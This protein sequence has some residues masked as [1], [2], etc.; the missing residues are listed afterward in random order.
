MPQCQVSLEPFAIPGYLGT[1]SMEEMERRKSGRTHI[2]LFTGIGGFDLGLH[3]AGFESRVMIEINKSCCKTLRANW[4]WEE[5]QKRQ[6]GKIVDNKFVPTGPMWKTKEEMKKSITWYQDREPVIIERDIRTVST[7]EILEAAELSVGECS[8]I[9]G[10]PPCQGFSTAN[11]GRCTDDP[12]NFAFKA[13]VRIVGEA[14]P[15]TFILENVPGMVSS[16]KG[17]VIRGIAKEFADCGYDVTWNILN[18]ANYGVPQNR[19]RVIMVGKR[20]DMMYIPEIGNPR[21]HMGC[22]PGKITHPAWYIKKYK[23][24]LT[25][26]EET[27]DQ[28]EQKN[29]K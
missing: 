5:M 1:K 23:F 28:E 27:H 20:V 9:S 21:L 14:F 15:R 26:Q 6:T 13:F 7:K 3:A 10:G 19:K 8:V 24:T 4:H 16:T 29:V 11:T 25:E 17:V 22:Q 2:S 18:A 12:R